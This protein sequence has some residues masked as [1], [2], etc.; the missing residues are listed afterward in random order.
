M[1][2]FIQVTIAINSEEG[3]HRIAEMLVTRRLAASC[4]VSGPITS[5]Y[6]WKGKVE[7]TQEWICT[8]ETRT[9]LCTEIEQATKEIHGYEMP[10]I[11]ATPIVDGNQACFEWINR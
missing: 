8:A 11:L 7:K 3:A 1:A 5:R 10:G 9:D 6:W 4:W 2:D